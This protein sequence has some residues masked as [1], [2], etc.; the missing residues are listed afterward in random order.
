MTGRLKRRSSILPTPRGSPGKA[1]KGDSFETP[2][3]RSP[4]K[5]KGATAPAPAPAPPPPAPFQVAELDE[6]AE[7]RARNIQRKQQQQLQG[8]SLANLD[9]PA[10]GGKDGG[11]DAGGRRSLD[12]VSGLS[13]VQLAEH[14]QNCLKLSAENKISTKNAFNLQLI[15][16]MSHMIKKKESDL[17][18]FQIAA[19]TLDASSKI[20]AYRVDNVY[21]TTLKVASGLGQAGK[22]EP[23]QAEGGEGAGLGDGE[24]GDENTEEGEKAKKKRFK[25]SATVE[26]NLKNIN[27]NKLE[28]EFDVDPLFKKTTQKFDG[29]QGGNQFL[30]TLRLQGESAQLLFDSDALVECEPPTPLKG[31]TKKEKESFFP[32]LDPRLEGYQICP[33][34]GSFSFTRWSV[35]AE[36]EE[37]SRLNDSISQ[38]S[39]QE[40]HGMDAEVGKDENAFDAF[41][42]PEPVEDDPGPMDCDMDDP[43]GVD[44]DGNTSVWS[45]RALGHAALRGPTGLTATL[46][47][48]P[49]D[50]ISVLTTAPLEYSYFD[51]GKLGAWAGPK[52]WKLKPLHRA[53]AGLVEPGKGLPG[54]KKKV[55][56]ELDYSELEEMLE[57]TQLKLKNLL[58][59]PKKSVKLVDKTMKGW[60]RE[61]NTLPEDLHYSGHELVRLKAVDKMV[62]AAQKKLAEQEVDDVGD[63]DYDNPGDNDGYCPGIDDENDEYVSQDAA[64]DAEMGAG[65]N[66]QDEGEMDIAQGSEME[67]VQAP[68]LVDKAALQIG[69][70]KTAKKV[71]MK[72]I[73]SATWNILTEGKED[74][75]DPSFN[76]DDGQET[77]S[78][79]SFTHLYKSLKLPHKLPKSVSENLSVPLA[80]IALLHLCNEKTLKLVPKDEMDDFQIQKG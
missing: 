70:A 48:T 18:N 59:L 64:P 25:K 71:D 41:A 56:E 9:T 3:R 49:A 68:K 66:S 67:L 77:V 39:S 34:F 53:G 30:A 32:V 4:T 73:K 43:G 12:G 14:Y 40:G 50:M 52:H 16:Y 78:E 76:K 1:A 45:E 58:T 29:A 61:R 69:Y 46:A 11:Q 44:D 36:D 22:Q 28:L 57:E 55:L 2:L 63:Y 20:Y 8:G 72:K 62:V 51:H 5:G 13:A 27:L 38:S 80:F 54:R 10:V 42:V 7:R 17:N 19:G 15:D 37:Y 26:K 31:V 23:V 24:H 47:L 79:T 60:N 21:D 74:Y 65:M 33:T 75:S 6:E 35:D